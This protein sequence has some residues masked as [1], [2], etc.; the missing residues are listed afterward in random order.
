VITESKGKSLTNPVNGKK[1]S[2]FGVPAEF[3]GIRSYVGQ[4]KGRRET[5][6][7]SSSSRKNRPHTSNSLKGNVSIAK[8]SE[9]SI[10]HMS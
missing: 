9:Y 10:E 4:R 8:G 5:G 3:D 6:T 7:H 2:A 1:D